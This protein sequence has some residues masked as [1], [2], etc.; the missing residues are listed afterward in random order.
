[1][2]KAL[3]VL[4]TVA[5]FSSISESA[6]AATV[7]V[8]SCRAGLPQYSTIQS[9]VNAAPSGSNVFICPG[10]YHEQVV[11][12]KALDIRGIV[13]GTND[14]AII[15]PPVTGVVQNTTSL[16]SGAAIAAQVLVQGTVGVSL[17]N[18][19]VDG[20]NNGLTE[21][22]CAGPD[23]IGVYFQNASGSITRTAVVN[24]TMTPTNG[25]QNGLAIFVQ[26]GNS[27]TS[28][29][30]VANNHVQNYQKN[31]ITGNEVG[32]TVTVSGNTVF[33]QGPTNGAAENSIQIGFGAAGS[34]TG[35]TVG[36]DI[37]APDTSSDSADAASGILVYASHGISV[38]K[39]TVG[40][41]QFGIGFVTD[42]SVGTAD[43]GVITSNKIAA[44][45]IFDAIELCNNH[46][47]VQ[48]NTINGSDEAAIHVDSG[49]ANFGASGNTGSADTISSNLMNGACA[50]ILIGTLAGSNTI[51][52]NT[53]FNTGNTVL[54]ADQCLMPTLA[55]VPPATARATGITKTHRLPRP[56][57]P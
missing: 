27:G 29:V 14:A 47:M 26:S 3:L 55:A 42:P 5:F 25:C 6:L 2:Y 15:V 31:G 11:I 30:T 28:N 12:N 33:G 35:N 43:D 39:N 50:G 37:W 7:E 40:N 9:A 56:A 51:G 22:S 23:F 18:I 32:T 20:S 1:M 53:F 13:E 41:T 52:T 24:Q 16:S 38:S 34:I 49:C 48:G 46:N 21:N 44:T 54:I 45:H 4:L 36:D 10:R 57:R 19:T 8:G 17:T